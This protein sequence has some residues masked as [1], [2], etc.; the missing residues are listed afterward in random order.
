MSH[1]VLDCF[2]I[3]CVI[4]GVFNTFGVHCGYTSLKGIKS[5]S[6]NVPVSL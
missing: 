5:S 4:T 6:I 3:I 1:S 2:G